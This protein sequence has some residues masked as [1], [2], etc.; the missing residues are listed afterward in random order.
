[1]RTSITSVS[2]VVFCPMTSIFIDVATGYP[3]M[4]F[5]FSARSA[6]SLLLHKKPL[7]PSAMTSRQPGVSAAIR[8]LH[9]LAPSS[10]LRGI[11]S[12]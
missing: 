10:R 1:M 9:M 3:F 11:P 4:A 5:I 2:L 6:T 12:L 8:A 7:T